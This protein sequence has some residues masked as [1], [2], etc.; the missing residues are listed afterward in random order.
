M[1]SLTAAIAF[2]PIAYVGQG[3]Q[4]V[5]Y[6]IP[7]PA[8]GFNATGTIEF[9][10]NAPYPSQALPWL[11]QLRQWGY[12]RP[13][14]KPARTLAMVIDA[15]DPGVLGNHI[16]I[17]FTNSGST[18]DMKVESTATYSNTLSALKGLLGTETLPGTQPGLV[19]F[20][21]EDVA[22]SLPLPEAI[23]DAVLDVGGTDSAP[24]PT[25][26][27]TGDKIKKAGDS[28]QTAFQLVARKPGTGGRHIKVTISEAQSVVTLSVTWIHEKTG[29]DANALGTINTEFGYMISVSAP[30]GQTFAAPDAG[31]V[32]LAEGTDA[33]KASAR[34]V[35]P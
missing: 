20:R 14:T 4:Y 33:A 32:L 17:T 22:L 11:E 6:L 10:P 29:L 5:Q 24:V 3:P 9:V 31:T 1:A 21:D 2:G 19:R 28:S 7:V 18:F 8:F 12:I 15:A 35:T 13:S 25:P 30:P 16:T 34:P 27:T 26:A 23:T